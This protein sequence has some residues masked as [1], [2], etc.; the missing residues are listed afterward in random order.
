MRITEIIIESLSRVAYH[1]TG[2]HAA[3]KI[4]KSGTFELSEIGRAHV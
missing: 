4:L 2:L 1:Y 3:E